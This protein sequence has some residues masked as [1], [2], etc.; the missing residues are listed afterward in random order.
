MNSRKLTTTSFLLLNVIKEW[1]EGETFKHPNCF[2]PRGN[3]IPLRMVR[4]NEYMNPAIN[5][6][7]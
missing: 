4:I 1:V 3:Q 7:R 2:G 6:R 5:V